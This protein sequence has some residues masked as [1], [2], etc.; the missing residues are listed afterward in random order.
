MPM[1]EVEALERV[2]WKN[3]ED[4]EKEACEVN[5]MGMWPQHSI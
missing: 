1:A 5:Q 4:M 2:G 3:D